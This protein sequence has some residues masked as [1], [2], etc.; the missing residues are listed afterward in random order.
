[1]VNHNPYL[2]P[3][4]TDVEAASSSQWTVRFWI[5][6]HVCALIVSALI[7]LIDSGRIGISFSSIGILQWL[8]F[9]AVAAW[10][11]C[12][13]AIFVCILRPSMNRRNCWIVITLESLLV[14]AHPFVLLP[15]FQ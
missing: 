6:F 5:C 12:P 14:L 2:S 1:M 7:S 3:I 10:I 4:R 9:P 11:V 13:I 8:V 15:A